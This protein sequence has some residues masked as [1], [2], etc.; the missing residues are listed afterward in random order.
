MSISSV[1]IIL[2]IPASLPFVWP[3]ACA[4]YLVLA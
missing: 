2:F 4:T 1:G 3:M